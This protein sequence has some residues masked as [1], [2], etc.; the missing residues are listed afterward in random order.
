MSETDILKKFENSSSQDPVLIFYDKMCTS[1]Q[2]IISWLHSYEASHS[3][4]KIIYYDLYKNVSNRELLENYMKQYNQS[5]LN[6]PT[7]FIGP[8]GLEGN[9][10][11]EIM[12]EPFSL[13]YTKQDQ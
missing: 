10:T 6:V 2:E 7:A 3:G 11:I 4:I 1:C 5:D 12:F 8:A 13:I 9:K